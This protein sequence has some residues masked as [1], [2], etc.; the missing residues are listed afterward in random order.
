MAVEPQGARL[1]A[2][3]ARRAHPAQGRGARGRGEH[4]ITVHLQRADQSG[5]GHTA[6]VCERDPNPLGGQLRGHVSHAATR[7]ASDHSDNRPCR[8]HPFERLHVQDLCRQG[9][10][11]VGGHDPRAEPQQEREL[12]RE[13]GRAHPPAGDRT[14]ARGDAQDDLGRGRML[15]AGPVRSR[16]GALAGRRG[17]ARSDVLAQLAGVVGQAHEV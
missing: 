12:P 14:H 4:F 7:R 13:G 9:A 16:T 1:R 6:V 10:N 17:E 2:E 8:A 11:L 5:R 3:D 15:L